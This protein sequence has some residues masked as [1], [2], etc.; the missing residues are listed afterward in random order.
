LL[1]RD[2]VIFWDY[3][4][5]SVAAQKFCYANG[6]TNYDGKVYLASTRQNKVWQFDFKDGKMM[7]EKEIAT[8]NGPDNIRITD[9]DLYVACHLRFIAF[10]KHMQKASNYSPTTVYRVNPVTG[11]KSVAFFDDGSKISAGSTGLVFRNKL[12]VSG[13]F[14][15]RMAIVSNPQ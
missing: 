13:V 2:K 5:C 6:I 4:R 14:D 10:L 1:K 9:G 12:Y 8:L 7:N 15:P 3:N 11:K